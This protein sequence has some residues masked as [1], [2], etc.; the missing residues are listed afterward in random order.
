MSSSAR[1]TLIVVL[2]APAVIL[3]LLVPLYDTEDPTLFGF[4]FYYWFQLALI[5]VAV[6]LTV[7]A[8]YLAK[9]ADRDRQAN[10]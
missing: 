1:W 9:A 2:L 4:P 10:R 6:V 7:I 3:P 8:Y 5:P